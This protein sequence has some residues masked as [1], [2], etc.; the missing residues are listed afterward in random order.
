MTDAGFYAH[1]DR[2]EAGYRDLIDALTAEFG[3]P[4]CVYHTGGGC[5]AL[6]ATVENGYLLITDAQDTLSLMSERIEAQASGVC[7]GYAVGIYRIT[8]VGDDNIVYVTD[9]NA[10]TSADVIALTHKAL[11]GAS[12]GNCAGCGWNHKDGDKPMTDDCWDAIAGK[13]K[14]DE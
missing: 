13:A 2:Y 7:Y 10:V 5:M 6:E 4:F 11:K 1:M 3:T 12:G 14:G 8:G 9:S